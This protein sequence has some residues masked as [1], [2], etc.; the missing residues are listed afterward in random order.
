[1][2]P[3]ACRVTGVRPIPQL[4]PSRGLTAHLA[5]ACFSVAALALAANSLVRQGTLVVRTIEVPGEPSTGSGLETPFIEYVPVESGALVAAVQ[6]H[7]E[8]VLERAESPAGA[9]DAS[10]Q[11]ASDL[12]RREIQNYVAIAGTA[13]ASSDERALR[14]AV[15]RSRQQAE[16][17]VR[18]GDARRAL[19]QS[20]WS[21]LDTLD[22]NQREAIGRALKI[23]GRVLARESLLE[24]GRQLGVVRSHLARFAQPQGYPTSDIATLESA[25]AALIAALDP[26]QSSLSRER[27]QWLQHNRDLVY[28]FSAARESLVDTDSRLLRLRK[29]FQ[30]RT[31]ALE[32]L[33]GKPRFLAVTIRAPQP[34]I[35]NDAAG[36]SAAP[37]V[38]TTT[39]ELDP[40]WHRTTLLVVSAGALL[41]LLALSV[42]LFVRVVGP[43][44]RLVQAAHGI[45]RGD[46]GQRVERGGIRELDSLAVAFNQ[47]A[48]RLDAAQAVAREYQ[49]R[50]EVTVE[51][52]TSQLLHLA[53]HDPL[54]ELPNR[55][56]LFE[57]LG[58]AVERA[59]RSGTK[60]GVFVLDVD[61]FKNLNDSVGHAY[62]D[63]VLQAVARRLAETTPS[64]GYSARL[65]GDEFT[66]LLEDA[67]DLDSI[68]SAGHELVR[69]FQTPLEI[70][71]RELVLSVSIGASCYPEHGEDAESLLRAAD[72][73]LFRAKALG[74][75]QLSLYTP[76]LLAAAATRFSTEQ[77]LRHALERNELE[78]VFQPEVDA[79]TL[80]VGLVEA[81]LRW[82]LPDGRL[83]APGEFLSVAEES[84]LILGISDWV[85]RS[86]IEAAEAWRRGPWPQARIAI[87]VSV[88]QVLDL[89][90]ESRLLSLIER[91]ALPPQ[92]VELELTENVLQTGR[93][94]VEAISRLR[95]AGIGIAL[96]DFGTGYSSLASLEHLPLTRVK[97]D[98]SL[99]ASIDTNARSLAITLSIAG[100]CEQLGLEMTAEGVERPE[101]LALLL[102]HA[103]ISLQGFLISRPVSRADLPA[104]IREL[105][106][107]LRSLLLSN[108]HLRTGRG[109]RGPASSRTPRRARV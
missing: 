89:G 108:Q 82:R 91:H 106:A 13:L 74:R 101:Q 96:D 75:S 42:Q 55:R 8:A 37:V 25:E 73:A 5:L 11:A 9:S 54:T 50:L 33:A 29:D 97:L 20:C 40:P 47:M 15:L 10:M 41:V 61:N 24:I 21:Q 80:E 109:R 71:G 62:G 65:G 39:T 28:A 85:L 84:G 31:K 14:A 58:T 48:E 49:Q 79:R 88:R 56:E 44:R 105:P 46:T 95:A 66:V 17:L 6:R 34:S 53:A 70:D 92:C 93:A 94:T 64:H 78:L 107:R 1:M 12:L 16:E 22:R 35:G 52:R 57:E 23:F 18:L 76:D 36:E 59:R 43:V 104:R 98:Q 69:A 45:A 2:A 77:G 68:G 81:L 30:G 27:Q 99:V 51:Q 103:S 19:L 63:R 67:C 60:V 4:S 86:A 7:S 100:L 26:G 90:F 32:A 87:N 83:A 102:P 38:R 3:Y 72:A